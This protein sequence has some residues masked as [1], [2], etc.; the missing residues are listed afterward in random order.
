[1]VVE[2]TVKDTTKKQIGKLD[3][4]SLNLEKLKRSSKNE[5]LDPLSYVI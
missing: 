4:L 2:R 5:K 1:M 3:L